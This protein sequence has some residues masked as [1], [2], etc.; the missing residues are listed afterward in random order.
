MGPLRGGAGVP[1]PLRS[2]P[3]DGLPA[4]AER[5]RALHD[6]RVRHRDSQSTAAASATTRRSDRKPPNERRI[7]VLGDSLVLSVQ[8]PFAQTF[9]ELLERRLNAD[10]VAVPLPGHQRRRAGIRAG[11][12]AA[13]LRVDGSDASARPRDRNSL[14]RQRRRGGRRAPASRLKAGASGASAAVRDTVATQFRRL[15]RRSM[16]LQ[17]LRLRVVVRDRAVSRSCSPRP[18]RRSRVT[19]RTRRRESPRASPSPGNASATSRRS[20]RPQGASTA[21]ALMP[22]RFQVDDAD[23]GRL[24]E[25]VAAAGGELQRDAASER[26]DAALAALPLPRVDLLPALRRALPG[27]GPLLP[28]DGAPHAARPRGRGR[29]PVSLHRPAAPGDAG[30]RAAVPLIHGLQLAPLPLVLRRRLRAVPAAAA[31]G[32]ELAAARRELLLLRG[33]GL[34]LP[35]PPAR[36]DGRRLLVR[37]PDRGVTRSAS[38]EDAAR[39]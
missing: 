35:R 12:G 21:I 11:R 29:S 24:K 1:G 27:P 5:A 28:G 32:A 26:F 37:P 16:V 4:E 2:D 17:L 15:V 34:A 10:A 30:P 31:P 6:V 8:V 38:A 23:Y 36:L 7:V 19:R 13:L 3:D 18:S 20:P 22:A 14:R 39:A 25:A 9:G 33:L